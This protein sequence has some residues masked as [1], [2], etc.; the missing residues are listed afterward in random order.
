MTNKNEILK[1]VTAAGLAMALASPA[2][3][4]LLTTTGIEVL[5]ITGAARASFSNNEKIRIQAKVNNASASPNFIRFTFSITSPTGG[6]VFSHTGN[7]VPGRVGNAATRVSGLSIDRIFT[8]PGIYTLTS[9]AELDGQTVS[10][11][12]TFTVSSPNIILLYPPNGAQDVGDKPL[13]FRW[14][15]S[16]A[17]KYRL[18]VGETPSFFNSV[19]SETT[20]GG[21]DFFSYP[22]NPSDSRARLASGTNYYWKVE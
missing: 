10:Q 8:G 12:A 17:T 19:F 13:I 6:Q 4:G 22:E 2:S 3:A 16:G 15:S 7:A 9:T 5:D 18:T 21:Q 20:T 11:S 14:N 1:R